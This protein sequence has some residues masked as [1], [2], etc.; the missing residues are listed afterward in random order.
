M[1]SFDLTLETGVE[2]DSKG[3]TCVLGLQITCALCADRASIQGT[4]VCVHYRMGKQ[5]VNVTKDSQMVDPVKLHLICCAYIPGFIKSFS[6]LLAI[7]LVLY[8]RSINISIE[9][10]E[11][12]GSLNGGAASLCGLPGEM[13]RRTLQFA[14]HL[15]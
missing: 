5:T 13:T 10:D 15:K 3:H 7:D 4:A 11:E 8:I 14:F 9:T 2:K 6:S 12:L 1:S